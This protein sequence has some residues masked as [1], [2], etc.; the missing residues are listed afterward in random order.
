MTNEPEWE[1]KFDEEFGKFFEQGV[2]GGF[3]LVSTMIGV[4]DLKT[5]IKEE[6]EKSYRDG[7]KKGAISSDDVAFHIEREKSELL[8]KIEEEVEGIKPEWAPICR[9]A[10]DEVTKILSKY[11]N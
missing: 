4:Q 6:K 7:Y 2:S 5:F 8:S 1:N 10:L 9:D 3:Y 11:K